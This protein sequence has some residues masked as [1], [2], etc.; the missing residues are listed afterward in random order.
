MRE[1]SS[2]LR[3]ARCRWRHGSG[4]PHP[5]ACSRSCAPSLPWGPPPSRAA[6]RRAEAACN[7]GGGIY[8]V[9]PKVELR[10]RCREL[11][12]AGVF[13]VTPPPSASPHSTMCVQTRGLYKLRP[14]ARP[15]SSASSS[16]ARYSRTHTGSKYVSIPHQ[17]RPASAP[18]HASGAS[19]PPGTATGSKRVLRPRP[20]R[21][22]LISSKSHS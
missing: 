2:L 13:F 1:S 7:N 10:A 16:V 19:C 9:Q 14:R 11:R 4:W 6:R 15:P 8:C 18:S 3:L 12:R 20:A 21:W 17:L 22:R 5:R